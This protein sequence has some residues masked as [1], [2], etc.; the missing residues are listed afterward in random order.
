[1]KRLAL[2]A[3]LFLGGLAHAGPNPSLPG[4]VRSSSVITNALQ[5][6]PTE[7]APFQH[8]VKGIWIRSVNGVLY[9]HE[10]D[11]VDTALLGGHSPSV[12][13]IE[14][15]LRDSV[16]FAADAR[17][18]WV[19]SADGSLYFHNADG[20]NDQVGGN[21][22][23]F[24]ISST[25]FTATVG[26]TS[27]FHY[28]SGEYGVG[29]FRLSGTTSNGETVTIGSVVF[30]FRTSGS[31]SGGHTL[32]NVSGGNSA[33]QSI[34]A[35]ASAQ[36]GN[37]T[38][39]QEAFVDIPSANVLAIGSLAYPGAL[40]LSETCANGT[41]SGSA[42]V[43]GSIREFHYRASG[44]HTVVTENVNA[45]AASQKVVV[46]AT[47]QFYSKQYLAAF[48]V[49]SSAGVIRA[50]TTITA[51]FVNNFIVVADSGGVIQAGDLIYWSTDQSN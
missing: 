42:L 20:S 43:N 16:P 47:G 7:P 22:A 3:L 28:D 36:A 17:G 31:V 9:F 12:Y 51:T 46:G 5:L 13:G 25:N 10:S 6:N 11:G 23:G 37:V 34:T 40:A 29:T 50:L 44:Q 38:S 27:G 2:S 41:V 49:R 24:P 21:L 1:M 14:F 45:L 35:L 19:S 39:S 4:T 33:S 48:F 15:T 26:N 30:E 8:G 32:V 18:L